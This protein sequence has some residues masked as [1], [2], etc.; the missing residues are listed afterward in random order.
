MRRLKNILII[1][2]FSLFV[3]QPV[4]GQSFLN[5][6]SKRISEETKDQKGDSPSEELDINNILKGFGLTTNPVP[7]ADVY[8]F[9]HL[10]QM[11]LENF[12]KRGN[13]SD[14][15]E[16]I[17]HFNPKTK[18]MAY[19]SLSND[20]ESGEGLFIIDTENEAT[21]ILTE[22]DGEKAGIVYGM[23]GYF[24]SIGED[25]DVDNLDI[26]E[27]PETYL[28]NPNVKKTGRTKTIAGYKCEEFIYDDEYTKSN[29]WITKDMKLNTK[30]FMSTLFKTSMAS[31]GMGWGYMMEATSVNKESGEKSVMTVTKVDN[32]SNVKFR[33]S[34]YKITNLGSFQP[35]AE[36]E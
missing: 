8:T 2:I 26:S 34:D 21:I 22:D 35:P 4:H 23:G 30:D 5:K 15:N 24:E 7:T 10:I 28:A 13:K 3:L 11:H 1:S 36:D 12:D 6:L 31:H 20:S 16:F 25:Y 9:D 32:N 17:T 27:T 14:E 29:I 33:M 18:S 19:Q